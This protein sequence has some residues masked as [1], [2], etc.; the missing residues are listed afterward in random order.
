MGV[1]TRRPRLRGT[2]CKGGKHLALV[3][4]DSLNR[5]EVLNPEALYLFG[6]LAAGR[7]MP[8]SDVDLPHS[9]KSGGSKSAIRFGE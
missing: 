3:P 2:G 6:S 1:V 5:L 9:P 7:G 8:A 4:E